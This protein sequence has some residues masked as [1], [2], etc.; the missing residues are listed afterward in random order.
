MKEIES[1]KSE[2]L[3]EQFV[4]LRDNTRLIVTPTVNEEEL[5][6]LLLLQLNPYNVEDD[7]DMMIG[8]GEYSEALDRKR[9]KEEQK[10]IRL[11]ILLK[12]SKKEKLSGNEQKYLELWTSNGLEGEE[13][14]CFTG[15]TV[16]DL[17]QKDKQALERFPHSKDLVEKYSSLRLTDLI[18]EL[19]H[20]YSNAIV[21][22]FEGRMLLK[23]C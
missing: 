21:K 11:R 7:V 8:N 22:Q 2:I 13:S 15:R 6:R 9:F 1:Y 23:K 5:S 4:I 14:Y 12:T 19:G 10:L 20:C 3:D 16:G 18:L 17:S